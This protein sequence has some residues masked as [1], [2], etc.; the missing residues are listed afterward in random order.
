M[1]PLGWLL[2][3]PVRAIVLLVVGALPLGVELAD[4]GT[5]L[6]SAVLIGL[7]GTVLILPM[8]VMRGT[9]HLYKL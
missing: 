2:Q 1:G 4:F 9:Q 8:K 5:A 3:W 7:L 6:W